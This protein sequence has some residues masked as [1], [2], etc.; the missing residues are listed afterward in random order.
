MKDETDHEGNPRRGF[1]KRV[2]VATGSPGHSQ[3]GA[4]LQRRRPLQDSIARSRRGACGGSRS[5]TQWTAKMPDKRLDRER[6]QL[7]PL[8]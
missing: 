5:D 7:R 4:H 8:P 1:L 6:L 2:A 3:V